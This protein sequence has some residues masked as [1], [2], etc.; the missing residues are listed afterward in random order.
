MTLLARMMELALVQVCAAVVAHSKK[1][2]IPLD[3]DKST[4]PPLVDGGKPN[5]IKINAD[6]FS[7]PDFDEKDEVR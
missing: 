2:R 3:Y 1:V 5:V 4:V 7:I 6:I